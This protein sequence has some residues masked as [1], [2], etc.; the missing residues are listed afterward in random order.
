MKVVKRDGRIQDFDLDKIIVSIER[1]SDD[2]GEPMNES[3]AN[4]AAQSI[5]KNIKAQGKEAI[6][7][8]EIRNIVTSELKKLG[9][10]DIAAAY[11]KSKT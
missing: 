2:I 4:C 8:Q 3:D 6:T 9:F 10:S 7:F 1:A 5:E 11:E